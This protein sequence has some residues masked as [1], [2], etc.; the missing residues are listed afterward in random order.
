MMRRGR[1]K[2]NREMARLAP[3]SPANSAGM[4]RVRPGAFSAARQIGDAVGDTNGRAMVN[5][6]LALEPATAG[7]RALLLRRLLDPLLATAG[8]A[9]GTICGCMQPETTAFDGLEARLRLPLHPTIDKL[10][11]WED[12]RAAGSRCLPRMSGVAGAVRALYSYKMLLFQK[13]R[14]CSAAQLRTQGAHRLH[15]MLRPHASCWSAL[16]FTAFDAGIISAEQLYSDQPKEIYALFCIVFSL[17]HIA[18]HCAVM[19]QAAEDRGIR[20]GTLHSHFVHAAMLCHLAD[21]AS[22]GLMGATAPAASAAGTHALLAGK[23]RL[24]KATAKRGRRMVNT[25]AAA[26]AA[27]GAVPTALAL[28]ALRAHAH[29]VLLRFAGQVDGLPVPLGASAAEVAEA[30]VALALYLC[31][32][33]GLRLTDV[34]HLTSSALVPRVRSKT[35]A[36]PRGRCFIDLAQCDGK[37]GG[38][39][40]GGFREGAAIE[41]DAA[42]HTALASIVRWLG[43]PRRAVPLCF[44]PAAAAAPS[45]LVVPP[46]FAGPA[47]SHRTLFA[48]GGAAARAAVAAAAAAPAPPAASDKRL[49]HLLRQVSCGPERLWRPARW[50]LLGDVS[51]RWVRR[52]CFT[53]SAEAWRT[54]APFGG[55]PLPP[56]GSSRTAA[57]AHVGALGGTS[58]REVL[59]TYHIGPFPNACMGDATAVVA[60]RQE[61]EEAEA[62]SAEEESESGSS[63]SRS[64]SKSKSKSSKSSSSKSSS[65]SSSSSSKSSSSSSSSRRARCSDSDDALEFEP[66]PPMLRHESAGECDDDDGGALRA[67][68]QEALVRAAVVRAA[69][70]DADEA[71]VWWPEEDYEAAY[72]ADYA[73]DYEAD[74]ES[75][76]AAQQEQAADE[77][78]EAAAAAAWRCSSVVSVAS[79]THLYL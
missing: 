58:A 48:E 63:R 33:L 27:C 31:L 23:A 20:A 76:E 74:Y 12:A 78:D 28:E 75:Y 60:G 40:G 25:H 72:A 2:Q 64:S 46:V 77:D 24:Q 73:A 41:L 68:H 65:K 9:A 19:E 39:T 54:G 29:G 45:G 17:A 69:A 22:P 37:L 38:C 26:E 36:A 18:H 43:A 70:A 5:P 16:C 66:P 3:C 13:L 53:A 61:A 44:C 6:T 55:L 67:A 62:S 8:L 15:A 34:Q 51:W 1:K 56:A 32:P 10:D 79:G 4:G 42:T 52:W 30:A 7:R 47:T 49:L 21:S 50:P 71:A 57:A 11:F 59:G 35:K 14:V